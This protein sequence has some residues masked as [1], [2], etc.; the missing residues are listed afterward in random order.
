[1]CS[2]Y[3][4]AA[5]FVRFR[6]TAGAKKPEFDEVVSQQLHGASQI[7]LDLYFVVKGFSVGALV[8]ALPQKANTDLICFK[9]MRLYLIMVSPIRRVH[10][11]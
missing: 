5:L 4:R 2:P 10:G 9:F 8:F 1:M 3:L 6:L 11:V 7:L